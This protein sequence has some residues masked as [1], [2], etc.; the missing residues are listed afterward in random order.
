MSG[1]N[2]NIVFFMPRDYVHSFI[3]ENSSFEERK[4]K[5][6]DN[7][8][9]LSF[10]LRVNILAGEK[11]SAEAKLN[12]NTTQRS[13]RLIAAMTTHNSRFPML[14]TPNLCKINFSCDIVEAKRECLS[15]S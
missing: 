12:L 8:M 3:I 13:V 4:H 1:E 5:R 2:A 7:I 15:R 9:H 11:E 14:I 6:S 10:P